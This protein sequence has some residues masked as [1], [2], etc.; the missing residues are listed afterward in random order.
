LFAGFLFAGPSANESGMFI[1]RKDKRSSNVVFTRLSPLFAVF[2]ICCDKSQTNIVEKSKFS[3]FGAC[4]GRVIS[5]VC[6]TYVYVVVPCLVVW[7]SF[8][9]MLLTRISVKKNGITGSKKEAH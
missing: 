4:S 7:E 6:E 2:K 9:Y 8:C 3:A 1:V 5:I